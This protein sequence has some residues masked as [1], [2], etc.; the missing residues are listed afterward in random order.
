[1]RRKQED[2]PPDQRKCAMSGVK[3]GVKDKWFCLNWPH[4]FS[5]ADK[6]MYSTIPLSTCR[7]KATF[8]DKK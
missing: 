3:A 1:L 8:N 2:I 5:N 4:T 6:L 7:N